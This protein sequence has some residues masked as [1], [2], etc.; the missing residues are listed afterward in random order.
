MPTQILRNVVADSDDFLLY[1]QNLLPQ[2]LKSSNIRKTLYLL[3]EDHFKSPCTLYCSDEPTEAGPHFGID[4]K[5]VKIHYEHFILF[6]LEESEDVDTTALRK[7]V[8]KLMDSILQVSYFSGFWQDF[9]M[10]EGPCNKYPDG[11]YS[12]YRSRTSG[13]PYP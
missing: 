8:F 1:L 10:L 7:V 2:N 11:L 13:F 3:M 5:L 12:L 9:Y 6:L 4:S